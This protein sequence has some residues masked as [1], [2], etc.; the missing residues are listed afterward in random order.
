MHRNLQSFKLVPCGV[1]GQEEEGNGLVKKIHR[2]VHNMKLILKHKRT[3][4]VMHMS[5]LCACY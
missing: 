4:L 3:K 2:Q 5:N 1:G